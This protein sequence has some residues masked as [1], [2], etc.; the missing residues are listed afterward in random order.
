MLRFFYQVTN[1]SSVVAEIMWHTIFSTTNTLN[2]CQIQLGRHEQPS[3]CNIFFV[4][5]TRLSSSSFFMQVT[6]SLRSTQCINI[7]IEPYFFKQGSSPY[8]TNPRNQ[9]FSQSVRIF[10]FSKLG[11]DIFN[12]F[13][14]AGQLLRNRHQHMVATS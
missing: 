13:L 1:W 11:I 3:K 9:Y 4:P 5:F 7:N 8:S 6:R 14:N 2:T 12:D 10:S